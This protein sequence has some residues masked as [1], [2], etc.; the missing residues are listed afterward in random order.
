M[1]S[2]LLLDNTNW[3]LLADAAGN[4][5]VAQAPYSLAQDV[6]SA[7]KLFL[8]ELWYNAPAGIPYF[9][10]I[11]GHAPPIGVFQDYM[12]RAALTVPDV[13]SATCVIS[14]IDGRTVTGTV[15]FID[16]NGTTTNVTIS[17]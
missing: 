4:I 13:V 1:K 7:I 10:E 6:A 17:Q 9:E 16:T 12:V 14:S 15:T 11:L 2:T 8:G 3:D 5:A